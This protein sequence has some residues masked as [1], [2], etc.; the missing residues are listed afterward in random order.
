MLCNSSFKPRACNQKY[1]LSKLTISQYL[2]GGLS[3]EAKRQKSGTEISILL[4]FSYF[5]FAL[6][7]SDFRS[8][9]V[10]ILADK[11]FVGC[12]SFH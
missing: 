7:N 6:G 8:V 12:S 11:T 2:G 10:S 9:S 4:K 5:P 1:A 3:K